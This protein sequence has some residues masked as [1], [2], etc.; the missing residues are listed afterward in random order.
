MTYR[1]SQHGEGG[2]GICELERLSEE[3]GAH[4]YLGRKPPFGYLPVALAPEGDASVLRAWVSCPV[5]PMHQSVPSWRQR[6]DG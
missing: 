2:N 1:R 6:L 3:D 4:L 5:L